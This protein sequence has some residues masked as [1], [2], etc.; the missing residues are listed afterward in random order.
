[1][2]IAHNSKELNELIKKAKA[3]DVIIF[4]EANWDELWNHYVNNI[5]GDKNE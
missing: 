4:D 3:G 5:L 1:M 2:E